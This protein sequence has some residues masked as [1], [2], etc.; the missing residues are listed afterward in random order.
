MNTDQS[1]D[2]PRRSFPS[3]LLEALPKNDRQGNR[4]LALLCLGMTVG[5]FLVGLWP[6]NFSPSNNVAWLPDRN[7]LRFPGGD[8]QAR[9]SAGGIA[10]TPEPLRAPRRGAAED[11]SLSIELWLKPSLEPSGGL[12]RIVG[13]TRDSRTES[14]IVA[15]W[16]AHFIMQV[17]ERE[18]AGRPR[19]REIGLRDFLKAGEPRFITITSDRNGTVLYLDGKPVKRFESVSLVPSPGTIAG[20]R[21]QLGNSPDGAS[22]WPGEIY[23]LAIYDKALSAEQVLESYREWTAAAKQARPVQEGIV[24]R[25]D[26]SARSGPWIQDASGSSNPLFIPT[27]LRFNRQALS[28]SRSAGRHVGDILVNVLGFVPYGFCLALWL[29]RARGWSHRRGLLIAV[30]LGALV[31][32]AIEL[33]QVWL[34]VRDSSLRD[35]VC[36]TGGTLLGA[37]IACGRRFQSDNV[38]AISGKA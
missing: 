2:Q 36:N 38:A 6:L 37:L 22:A 15:Q 31:S 28:G 16:Q 18:I 3:S 27:T 34:P 17:L 1:E 14:L 20:Q 13:L 24:G 32:L 12:Y 11:G 23:G 4:A 35:L 21:L 7:G 29:G 25:Y 5:L 26:F 8:T 30:A 9:Y 19:Y 10:F 33:I